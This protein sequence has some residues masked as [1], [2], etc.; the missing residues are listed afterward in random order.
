M[1]PQHHPADDV[2]TAYAAGALEPG[3]GLVVGAHLE[4]CAHCRARVGAFETISGAALTDMPETEIAPDALAKV[5][6]RLDEAPTP[7]AVDTRPLLQRLPLKP[8]RWVAPGVWVAAVDTPH[9]RD[10]RVYILSVG[11]GM[12]TARHEHTGAEFCTVLKG[13]YRDELGRFAAGDFA[14][15]HGDFNHQ[16]VVDG[17]ETCVCL[18]ATEGR[19]K[20][21]GLIGRIAFGFADV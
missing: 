16:P 1:S 13:A 18:F 9:A 15:A 12:P 3:F 11:P 19:L 5:M 17:D 6:A 21:Q 14:A 20:P 7:T 2:L 8:K 4:S 10:N